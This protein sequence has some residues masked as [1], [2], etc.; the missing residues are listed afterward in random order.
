M[1]RAISFLWQYGDLDADL[2]ADFD[3]YIETSRAIITKYRAK[4]NIICNQFQEMLC[5]D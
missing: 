2:D 5:C 1:S 3:K 4:L